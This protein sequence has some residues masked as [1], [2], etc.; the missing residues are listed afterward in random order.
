MESLADGGE[1]RRQDSRSAEKVF[2]FETLNE[3]ELKKEVINIVTGFDW[4][5]EVDTEKIHDLFETIH[6][7]EGLRRK[8][9]REAMR[10]RKE[11]AQKLME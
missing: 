9:K 8:K 3:N 5:Q 10:K 7:V 2:R 1:E 4:Q 6:A 11:N